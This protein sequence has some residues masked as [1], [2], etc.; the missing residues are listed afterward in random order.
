LILTVTPNPALDHT[1][2]IDALQFGESNRVAGARVRAGGKGLNVARVLHQLGYPVI[3]IAPV[4]GDT[5]DQFTAELEGS[6]VPHRLVPTG[7]ATR[8]SFALVETA[9]SRTTVLNETGNEPAA[10]DLARLTDTV[11]ELAAGAT[12]LVGSG[13]LPPGVP[14]DF[15]AGLVA[16]AHDAGIPAVID[17]TGAALMLAAQAGADLLKPNRRELAETTGQ[18]DPIA[19][20]ARLLDEGARM[21][22]V[23]LGED[24]MFAMSTD[25]RTPRFASLPRLAG[26][27]TGAGDAAVAA[28]ASCLAAGDT[29]GILRRA[30]AWSAAAVLAPLAGEVA[31][32]LTELEAAVLLT[33]AR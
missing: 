28:A 33:P 27:P 5:G 8:R 32:D 22:L 15:Y 2:T 24:G 11:R 17:T 4:G 30:T 10:S 25:E 20:A 16:I 9:S 7:K 1:Y 23:S 3:A 12:C 19:G 13:S 18:A 29:A 21:V 14:A 6:G 26:N 31:G